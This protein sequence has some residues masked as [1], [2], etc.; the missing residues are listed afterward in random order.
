MHLLNFSPNRCVSL[1]TSQMF[2]I[3]EQRKMNK[4][5]A[6]LIAAALEGKGRHLFRLSR[7]SKI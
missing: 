7:K 4:R 5:E 1:S 3:K 6:Q 2:T